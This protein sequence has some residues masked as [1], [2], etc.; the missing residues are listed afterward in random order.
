MYTI[1]RLR[2]VCLIL[3]CVFVLSASAQ[4]GE[5]RSQLSI[6]VN[7]GVA[8]STI[9]FDPTIKQYQHI[10]PTIGVSLRYTC[11]K[12]FSTVCA[13]QAELNYTQLGWKENILNAHGEKLKDTYKRDLGY[14]Q[15]PLLCRLA[16]GKE[17]GGV[18]FFILLGPQLG[19][20]ISG[21]SKQSSTWTFNENG[22]PDRPNNVYQQYSMK[23]DRK[24]DYG[25]TGGLGLEV[26]T[27][28]GQ[29]IMLDGRYYY[30]LNDM[31]DNGKADVFSRSAHMTI[32]V[33]ATYLFDVFNR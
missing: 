19:Y 8:L 5:R 21:T 15:L 4:I 26:N 12:Y 10:G 30:G 28:H 24:L 9:D 18:M 32:S 2:S 23:P 20:Y 1:M 16:W 27:K 33:R 3:A 31:Y 29:H 6:G 11:E 25:L 14:L 22:V 17:Q 7:G 13:L